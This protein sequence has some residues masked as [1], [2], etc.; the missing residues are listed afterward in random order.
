MWSGCIVGFEVCG[1]KFVVEVAIGG[2]AGSIARGEVSEDCG[3]IQ[4]TRFWS[5]G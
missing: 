2:T 4:L 1:M 5:D 3:S